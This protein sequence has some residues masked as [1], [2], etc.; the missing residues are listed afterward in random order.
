M[1]S[2]LMCCAVECSPDFG[3]TSAH[4]QNISGVYIDGAQTVAGGELC[5]SGREN[6]ALF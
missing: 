2:G 6:A 4:S 1:A 5:V 3:E